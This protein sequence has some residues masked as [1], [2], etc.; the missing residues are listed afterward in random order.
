V[1][2]LSISFS[3]P[4]SPAS[5]SARNTASNGLVAIVRQFI[6]SSAASIKGQLQF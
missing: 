2:L 4:Y 3:S 1:Q 5:A 6:A